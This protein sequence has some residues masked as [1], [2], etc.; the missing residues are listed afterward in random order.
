M[1]IFAS[2]IA[3]VLMFILML[4]LIFWFIYFILSN[5]SRWK[6]IAE[7]TSLSYVNEKQGQILQ[8]V[9]DA[10]LANSYDI[11]NA[12]LMLHG[13]RNNREWNVYNCLSRQRVYKR[14]Y[15][16]LTVISI[17]LHKSLPQCSITKTNFW[18]RMI[19]RI[20]PLKSE[21][22]IEEKAGRYR[23]IA[24]NTSAGKSIIAK[25]KPFLLENNIVLSTIQTNGKKAVVTIARRKMS[26][27]NELPN[28]IAAIEKFVDICDSAF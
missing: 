10:A 23:I 27:F 11:I 17:A 18:D 16:N 25:I 26:F 12:T 24:D 5:K 20:V 19:S 13:K 9:S 28:E 8:E 22:I 6:K 7:K 15:W 1:D 21:K 14:G 3:P 2:I 4:V